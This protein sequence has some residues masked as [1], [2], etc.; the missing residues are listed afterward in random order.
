MQR[1]L[2][3]GLRSILPSRAT[4]AVPQAT[5]TAAKKSKAVVPPARSSSTAQLLTQIPSDV[6]KNEIVASLLAAE[7][8][9]HVKS[10]LK[11]PETKEW[12][13]SIFSDPAVWA[14]LKENEKTQDVF[15]HLIRGEQ[16][17]VKAIL[18]EA[19]RKGPREL[20]KLLTTKLNITD[21]AKRKFDEIT[22]FQL[23][24]W[25]LNR[26]MWRMLL[27]FFK[28]EDL[29]EKDEEER[30]DIQREL[31]AA[32]YEQYREHRSGKLRY[33]QKNGEYYQFEGKEPG[34]EFKS[35]SN[36]SAQAWI[37]LSQQVSMKASSSSSCTA[38]TE[39]R[40]YRGI[41][42]D[43]AWDKICGYL[44]L[45]DSSAFLTNSPSSL[46]S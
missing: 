38:M 37:R 19:K 44:T 14:K 2:R 29:E 34:S 30:K 39:A 6:F 3:F 27:G 10:A 17:E 22:L 32:A 46:N 28:A 26:H 33:T 15:R 24:L 35:L 12:G 45:V 23:S 18:D 41:K 20:L 21:H 16:A 42:V 4:A 8:F 7:D 36:P 1:I 40:N 5:A 25:Y 11:A 13:A 43:C 9:I 31:R